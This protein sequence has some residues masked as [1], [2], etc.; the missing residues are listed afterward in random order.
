MIIICLAHRVPNRA[1]I[2]M[3]PLEKGQKVRKYVCRCLPKCRPDG[4]AQAKGNIAQ[5]IDATIHS[6]MSD[7][8]EISELRHHT[9]VDHSNSEAETSIW[10]DQ[11]EH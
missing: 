3:D 1:R 10:D 4:K 9:R 7:I 11:V 5:S 6:G 8:D 2:F